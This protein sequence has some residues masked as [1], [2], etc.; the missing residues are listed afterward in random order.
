MS[1]NI[2]AKFTTIVVVEA[3]WIYFM[4]QPC[5]M[6]LKHGN[7]TEATVNATFHDTFHSMASVKKSLLM[8]FTLELRDNGATH[9]LKHFV[10]IL[11]TPIGN[12]AHHLFK[13]E[14]V[15]NLRHIG[16]H[17]ILASQICHLTLITSVSVHNAT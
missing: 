13:H 2:M 9:F 3:A 11:A 16:H 17:H 1:V 6:L 14:Y 7:G 8:K 5:H 15:F 4:Y 10:L 12:S